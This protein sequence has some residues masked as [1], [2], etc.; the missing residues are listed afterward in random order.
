MDIHLL[1]TLIVF[2]KMN[3]KWV[4]FDVNLIKK[5][6][7]HFRMHN[8]LKTAYSF[9][10]STYRQVQFIRLSHSSGLFP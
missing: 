6:N 5:I 4:L 7:M 10:V 8:Y 3:F 2:L 9:T 1:F